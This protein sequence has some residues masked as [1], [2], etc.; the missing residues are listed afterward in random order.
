MLRMIRR[1]AGRDPTIPVVRS[2][3]PPWAESALPAGPGVA[4]DGAIARLRALTAEA[5]RA[6]GDEPT[7]PIGRFPFRVGRESRSGG[8]GL[9]EDGERRLS[10]VAPSNDLYLR[11]AEPLLHVS[12]EHFQIERDSDGTYRVRDRGSTCGTIV[13]HVRLEEAGADCV[14]S[15]FSV[16]VVGSEHSPY[17]YCFEPLE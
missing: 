9:F 12:R 17:V 1:L 15:P 6:V 11:D 14:V 10:R 2:P 4:N 16:I 13:G 3:V 7:I 5:E 8:G